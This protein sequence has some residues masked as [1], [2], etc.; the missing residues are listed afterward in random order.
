MYLPVLTYKDKLKDEAVLV[1]CEV[2]NEG[3]SLPKSISLTDFGFTYKTTESLCV[4]ASA[5][6]IHKLGVRAIQQYVNLIRS[7]V[8]HPEPIE[9]SRLS[10]RELVLLLTMF[11]FVAIAPKS[12]VY[13]RV[14][15]L[16]LRKPGKKRADLRSDLVKHGIDQ[17]VMERCGINQSK[18]YWQI[19]FN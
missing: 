2:V 1:D 13:S 16:E 15:F 14:N 3:D 17:W 8:D 18:E 4:F 5:N 12:N 11:R 19:I 9:K 10:F 6:K 7:Q